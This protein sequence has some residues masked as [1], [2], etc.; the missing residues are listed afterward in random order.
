MDWS[1]IA[2]ASVTVLAG[3]DINIGLD[4]ATNALEH[5]FLPMVVAGVAVAGVVLTTIDMTM[6]MEKMELREFIMA[7]KRMLLSGLTMG[8]GNL[9]MAGKTLSKLPKY[10]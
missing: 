6:P 2:A 4:V 5:N 10:R 1:K 3:H 8:M 7:V 9:A